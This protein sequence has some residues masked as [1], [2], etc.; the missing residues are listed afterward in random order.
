MKQVQ[1]LFKIISILF[2]SALISQQLQA[3]VSGKVFKD[4]NA[5]GIQTTSAPD[6]IE[7]GLKD[8]TVNTYDVSGA[9]NTATTVADGTYNISGGTGPYRVEFMLP[10]SFF[11]SNGGVSNSTVQFVAAGGTA[12]LGVNYPAQYCNSNNPNMVTSVFTNGD[13]LQPGSTSGESA[14]VGFPYDANGIAYGAGTPKNTLTTG[15]QTGPVWAITYQKESKKIFS[16]AFVKRHMGFGPLGVGGIYVTDVNSNTTTPFVNL[17]TIGVNLG[18]VTHTGLSGDKTQPSY[19]ETVY[20][21]VG[22]TGLGGMDISDDGKYLFVINLFEK[23]L[24]KIF[25]NNPAVAPNSG[26]ISNYTIPNPNCSNADFRPFA[27][28]YYR[29]KVYV[30][31][32]CSNETAGDLVGMKATVYEFDPVTT[33]FTEV[34]NYPITFKKGFTDN[35]YFERWNPWSDNFSTAFDYAGDQGYRY[36]AQYMLSDIEFDNDETMIIG[37]MD[38]FGHQI[39]FQ[40]YQ[41]DPSHTWFFHKR[42]VMK[43]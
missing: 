21:Q 38:R 23:K 22:K 14:I 7:P 29:G 20:G 4:F 16:A 24:H 41:P 17:T 5:N 18:S 30:G 42:N 10:S 9:L 26:D 27:C 36:Y 8:V 1:S 40:N 33:T 37:G 35:P 2:I 39:G 13:P 32:V 43:R 28:K 31:G 25:I 19:D 15:A 12:N 34:L 6:P 3:Q 11:A